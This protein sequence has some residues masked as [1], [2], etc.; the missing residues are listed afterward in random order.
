MKKEKPI[1]ANCGS[2]DVKSDAYADWNIET[3]RWELTGT[4]DKGSYCERCQ[5][6]CSLEWVEVPDAGATDDRSV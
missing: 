4:Y 6:E 3:Q 1:C 2:D 5:D